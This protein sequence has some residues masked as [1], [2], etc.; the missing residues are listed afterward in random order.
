MRIDSHQHF[1]KYDPGKYSW[2]TDEMS[3][4]RKDFFPE[5]LEPVLS[6]NGF[7]GCIAVQADQSEAETEALLKYAG[8]FAFIKGVVGWID[9]EATNVRERLEEFVKNPFLKGVRHTVWDEKGEFMTAPVF[10]NGI[11][12]LGEFG[13]TYD[14]LAFD[15]QLASAVEL[16][17]AFPNQKFVLDHMGRPKISVVPDEVWL[18]NI[19]ELEKLENCMCKIS[20]LVP[21]NK[22]VSWKTADFLPFLHVVGEAFGPERLMF[23]SDWPVCLSSASY[24]EVVKLADDFFSSYSGENK[25]RIFGR[26]A[27]DFY[28]LKPE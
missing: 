13:L 17:K 18:K 4:I 16:V 26:N 15:Y 24:Y 9:L 7:S 12:A 1:W 8:E 25:E 20:G 11:K 2:I 23:G 22:S 28:N 14:I 3:P 27:A 10:K 19:R 6:K 5:D 21:Q